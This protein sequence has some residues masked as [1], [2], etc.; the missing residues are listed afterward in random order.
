MP[1]LRCDRAVKVSHAPNA[2]Q[3]ADEDLTGG[4]FAGVKEKKSK[5]SASRKT[6][7][8]RSSLVG[9]L[10][11]RSKSSTLS[12]PLGPVQIQPKSCLG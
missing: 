12:T 8:P 2:G 9:Q 7:D 1:I 4:M 5:F 3:L 11:L 6:S 10:S